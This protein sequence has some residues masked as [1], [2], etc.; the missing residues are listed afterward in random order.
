MEDLVLLILRCVFL[1]VLALLFARPALL[2]DDLGP[3]LSSTPETAVLIMDNSASMGQSDGFHTRFE[4]AKGMAND[5]LDKLAAGSSCAL[6]LITDRTQSVISKPTQNFFLLRHALEQAP[7]SDGGSDLY[8]ALRTA[9]DLLKSAS[10]T[11]KEIFL[12]T[13]GQ[14]SAWRQ[15]EAIH[16]LQDQHKDIKF[17]VIIVGDKGEDNI[18]VTGLDLAGTP[19][20]INQPIPCVVTVSNWSQ[21]PVAQLSV[22]LSVDDQPPQDEGMIT[23]IAHGSSKSINLIARFKAAGYHSLTATIPGDLLPFDNQRSLAL[24][25]F[26]KLHAL[27]IEGSR[28]RDAGPGDG[29]FLKHAL[30]PVAREE[31]SQ[32]YVT[33]Q[34]ALPNALESS[35]IDN[36]QLIFLSNVARLST[37]SVK[38]LQRFVSNGG[39]LIIF[40]GPTSDANYYS[41]DPDFA[42]LLPATLGAAVETSKGQSALHWQSDHYEHPLT[43][44]WNDADSGNLGAIQVSKHFPLTVKTPADAKATPPQVVVRYSDGSPAVVEGTVG[45]GKVLIFSSTATTEWT[46]LPIHPSFVPLLAR[47]VS[48]LSNRP[49]SNVNIAPGDAFTAEV[50]V[51]NS[52]KEFFIAGPGDSERH[53][54]GTV[55]S[56]EHSAYVRYGDT[57][58]AGAYQLSIG[59]DPKPKIVFAVRQDPTESNLAQVAKQSVAG[60]LNP[61]LIENPKNPQNPQQ[62]RP[63]IPGPELWLPLAL[64]ALV[65]ALGDLALAH[66][67]SQPK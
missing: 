24:Y 3:L 63:K 36:N 48:R 61:P 52:G 51:D 17:S 11:Q 21:N 14:A 53:A 2:V 12:L 47:V 54:V 45:K 37:S 65:I 23:N 58:K 26:D 32:Y 35:T 18:A 4:Q 50:S 33:D 43:E 41:T 46:N 8:P 55:E 59:D 7:L 20:A 31:A 34:V 60:L 40:P 9:V 66:Y 39:G 22:K 56:G 38:N 64:A 49:E 57:S 25:A 19:P 10:G 1:A 27:I 6:Y 44:L 5:I 16:Q 67:S 15:L 28:N 42:S 29:F 62:N 13:D 30:V